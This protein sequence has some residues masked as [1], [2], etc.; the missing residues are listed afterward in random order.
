MPRYGSAGRVAT[1]LFAL[2][3]GSSLLIGR[4]AFQVGLFF[5]VLAVFGFALLVFAFMV[6]VGGGGR[7]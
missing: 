4:T 6:C 5:G 1:V 7:C 3:A 2:T